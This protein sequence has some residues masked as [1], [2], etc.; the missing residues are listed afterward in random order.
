MPKDLRIALERPPIALALPYDVFAAFPQQNRLP[1]AGCVTSA[2]H[3]QPFRLWAPARA[4][5]RRRLV[6]ACAATA[7]LGVNLNYP[8]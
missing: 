3:P 1:A 4:A 2:V 6:G 5:E 7:S 8:G